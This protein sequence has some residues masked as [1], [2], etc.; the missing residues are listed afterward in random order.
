MVRHIG[1]FFYFLLVC[2]SYGYPQQSSTDGFE[3]NGNLVQHEIDSL[4][5]ALNNTSSI[6]RA[7]IYGKL[8]LAF[9]GQVGDVTT[10]RLYA[11]SIGYVQNRDKNDTLSANAHYYYGVVERYEGKY[12]EALKNFEKQIESSTSVGNFLRVAEC[13][14]QM[15]VVQQQLGN[16]EKSLSLSHDAFDLFKQTNSVFGLA[17]TNMHMGNLYNRLDNTTEAIASHTQAL[18]YLNTLRPDLNVKLGKVRLLINLGISYTKLKEYDRSRKFF[19]ES[20]AMSES[21][22][23]KRPAATA[24]SN[25]GEVL[26]QLKQYDSALIFHLRALRLREEGSQREKIAMSQMRVGETYAFLSKYAAAQAYFEK[27]LSISSELGSKPMMRSLLK[28]LS[29]LYAAQGSFNKAY[30]Y[31]LL[32]AAMKDSIL[33]EETAR[34]LAELQTIYDSKE[35][36]KQIALMAKEKEVQDREMKRQATLNKAYVGGLLC[37]VIVGLLLFYIVRQRMDLAE[38]NNEIRQGELKLQL[39]ELEMKALRAQINPHFLFNCMNAINLMI[40]KG[41]TENA[42]LYLTKFSKL[43]RSIL[44]NAENPAVTLESEMLLVESYIQLEELRLPGKIGY[45]I[46][47]DKSIGVQNTYLPSMVLQPVI[48]NAIWHGLVHKEGNEKGI[49]SINV[50]QHAD[51]LLCTIEDN[52]VGR[53]KA[54][55]LRER[56]IMD[57]KSLGMKITEERLQLRRLDRTR[58][59][60]Q[61]TDLKDSLNHPVGTRVVIHIPIAEQ[62]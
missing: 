57:H 16:Y 36:D 31:H 53:A 61:I 24:L 18:T 41:H 3:D 29:G 6:T 33:T 42:T 12:A 47:V 59:C 50:R 51:E 26:I 11:D 5:K 4:R 55:L 46:S 32:F 60:I 20:L 54:Q 15:A 28:N 30:E 21:L 40:L 7:E 43:V 34:R 14:F 52:G 17:I 35:K 48:E 22:G 19:N 25:I 10:A 13:L 2:S 62:V 56:S 37:F 8:C 38:K 58:Q 39:K 23:T 44:E 49:I 9:A 1:V 27:A 45:S